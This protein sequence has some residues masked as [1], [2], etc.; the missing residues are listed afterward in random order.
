MLPTGY[1]TGIIEWCCIELA[2]RYPTAQVQVNQKVAARRRFTHQAWLSSVSEID[3][4]RLLRIW[5]DWQETVRVWR[6]LGRL[7]P[8]SRDDPVP[9]FTPLQRCNWQECLCSVHRPAH[10]L[11]VCKRCWLVSYCSS[12]CQKRCALALTTN[13]FSRLTNAQWLGSRWPQRCLR[14]SSGSAR[15]PSP[16]C[17]LVWCM[18]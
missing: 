7:I 5:P 18:I 1:T 16:T 6:A 4:R 9:A 11:K 15:M 8:I 2:R 12:R 14:E 13:R 3:R 17:F 10:H